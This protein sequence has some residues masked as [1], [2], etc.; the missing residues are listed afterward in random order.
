MNYNPPRCNT[1]WHRYRSICDHPNAAL[2]DGKPRFLIA[3]PNAPAPDW[4]PLA[5][6]EAAGAVATDNKT[7]LAIRAFQ[8]AARDCDRRGVETWQALDDAAEYKL[9]DALVNAVV[10]DATAM[11]PLLLAA[12]ECSDDVGDGR[13]G[14]SDAPWLVKIWRGLPDEWRALARALARRGQGR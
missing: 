5:A 13:P 6:Q 12:K 1:C 9:L 7:L 3:G 8:K 11:Q 14:S 4:C 2:V 10:L